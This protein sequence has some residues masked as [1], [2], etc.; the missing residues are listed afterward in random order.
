MKSLIINHLA[1]RFI[2]LILDELALLHTPLDTL[3]HHYYP[4]NLIDE[5]STTSL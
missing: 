3:R 2:V 1:D 5:F 4:S